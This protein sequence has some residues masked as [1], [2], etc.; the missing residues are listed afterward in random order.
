MQETGTSF[1]V[2]PRRGNAFTPSKT[3]LMQRERRMNMLSPEGGKKLFD[4]DIE[5]GKIVNEWSFNKGGVDVEMKDIANDT[6]AG[7]LT[8]EDTFLGI[9]QNRSV[10]TALQ[11]NSSNRSSAELLEDSMTNW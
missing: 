1:K 6:R 7:Q 4:T 9:G 10:P 3:M 5:T 11:S 8:D 2:T